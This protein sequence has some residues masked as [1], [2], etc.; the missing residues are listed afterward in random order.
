M[1]FH[2][3]EFYH[4]SWVFS[5]K[6]FQHHVWVLCFYFGAK[7]INFTNLEKSI[8]FLN[9]HSKTRISVCD[10]V[11][12]WPW[13]WPECMLTSHNQ[14]ISPLSINVTTSASYHCATDINPY[15]LIQYFEPVL[16]PPHAPQSPLELGTVGLILKELLVDLKVRFWW[17]KIFTTISRFHSLTSFHF[18]RV[19]NTV[20][21]LKIA[22]LLIDLFFKTISNF[23]VPSR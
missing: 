11:G 2:I 17:G 16:P 14:H 9:F 19:T 13:H 22:R 12:V 20:I 1:I 5:I 7:Y 6:Y 4:F 8:F 3:S 10:I 15:R 23:K 18:S 21:S